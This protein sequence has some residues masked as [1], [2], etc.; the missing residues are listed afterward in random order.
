VLEKT[1]PAVLAELATRQK[2][3]LN[4]EPFLLRKS[5]QL[6]FNTSPLDMKKL[7][8]DQGSRQGGPSTSTRVCA[9]TGSGTQGV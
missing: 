7:L 5:G 3:R 4:P 9:N 8:G 1:K 2:A 6:F